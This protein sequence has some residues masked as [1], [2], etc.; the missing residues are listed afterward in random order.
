MPRLQNINKL[1]CFSLIACA[2]T[3][4]TGNTSL[5]GEL[6]LSFGS[7]GVTTVDNTL[8]HFGLSAQT[9]VKDHNGNT[10]IA[11]SMFNDNNNDGYFIARINTS[12]QLDP[13]FGDN[14]IVIGDLTG[15]GSSLNALFVDSNNQILVQTRIH[16][17]LF[18]NRHTSDG[19]IDSSFGD[20]GTVSHTF[21]MYGQGVAI[22]NQNRI[23]IK[24]TAMMV[25]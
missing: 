9:S 10:L 22:D 15:P 8:Q 7:N 21:A 20:N 12:G 3:A 19:V 16:S 18:V 13:T 11:G 23:L 25:A 1:F 24:S 5:P 17:Q 2:V 6:D 4:Q 14:G